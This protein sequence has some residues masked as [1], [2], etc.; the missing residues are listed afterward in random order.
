MSD[1]EQSNTSSVFTNTADLTVTSVGSNQSSTTFYVV[2]H[3]NYSSF[4]TTSYQLM[5]PSSAG[6]LSIPQ[7]GGSLTLG[8]RDSKIHVVD[9]DVGGTTLLYSTAEVYT[10]KSFGNRTVLLV[11]GSAGEHHELAVALCTSATVIDGDASSVTFKQVRSSVVVAWDTTSTRRVVQAG[12]LQIF[13]LDRYSAYNYWVPELSSSATSATYTT[14]S[15]IASSIIVQ[16]GYLVRSAYFS[17]SELYLQADFNDTTSIEVIGAPLAVSSLFVN[18][19]QMQAQKNSLGDWSA[20]YSYDVP[21][22]AVP[23][24][25]G[26]A[27]KYHDSL[28]EVQQGYDDSLW[29]SADIIM[30]NN[31]VRNLTTPTTLY[32][33]DYGYT[34]GS[35]IYRGHFTASS[36]S[37]NFSVNTRGGSAYGHSVWL[38]QTFLGSWDG[39]STQ[40]NTNAT[41]TLSGLKSGNQH[42]ITIVIDHMG[43]DES[44]EV[45]T[46]E[47]KTPRGILD[48]D[49]GGL[50][51]SAVT[52][53][54]TGNLGGEDFIDKSRGPLNEGATYAERQGWHLPNPP[55]QSWQ[56]LSLMQGLTQPGIGFF[57]TSFDLNIPSGWDIPMSFVFGNATSPPVPY[58]VQLFVNGYQF[59]K[60]VNHIGPQ[61]SYPVPQGILNYNGTNW[62]ALTLWAHEMG[63]AKIDSFQLVNDRPIASGWAGAEYVGGAVYSQRVGAY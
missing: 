55:T 59:G 27:W 51:K 31:T 61:T 47:M 45:G 35:L 3:Y 33:A 8:P 19:Q 62:L 52:W 15:S 28:P 60:Y 53:K 56:S 36:S 22:F 54:L 13:L 41:Y 42:V 46:D 57:S 40:N 58:R 5:V 48:Y 1:P 37:T 7:L 2:R 17:G 29:T 34:A 43:M 30:T 23:D 18:G 50:S 25:S 11:Y 14:D 9:Y 32:G 44:G 6:N 12:N 24:L 4:D 10:W 39:V 26:L 20:S 38:D 49:I 63:G 21:S 16:A